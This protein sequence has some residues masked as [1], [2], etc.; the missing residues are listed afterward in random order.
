[1]L[2]VFLKVLSLPIL[3]LKNTWL[4][5]FSLILILSSTGCKSS[6]SDAIDDLLGDGSNDAPLLSA[7]SA[8]TVS[9]GDPLSIDVNNVKKGSPGDDVGMSYQCFFDTV[10]DNTVDQ[11]QPCTSLPLSTDRKSV[12]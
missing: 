1:M 11:T 12:V 8:Q 9:Q 7:I 2:N 6:S 4:P 5:F 3:Y 10:I